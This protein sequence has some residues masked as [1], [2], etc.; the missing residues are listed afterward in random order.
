M[1]D[2]NGFTSSGAAGPAG[3]L[4]D[5][6]A[7][8][9]DANGDGVNDVLITKGGASQRAGSPEYQPKF[10]LN[11]GRGGLSPSDAL[12]PLPISAGAVA[13][14]DF[15]RDGK[16]DLFLGGRVQPAGIRFRPGVRFSSI[17]AASS[18]T[19]PRRSRPASR[20]SAW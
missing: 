3:T 8:L 4:D 9:F 2:P 12:P 1:R 7:L 11:D 10:Y 19:S 15:D 16:L 6:P 17:A 5:G 13:A 18:R 14:A 20:K